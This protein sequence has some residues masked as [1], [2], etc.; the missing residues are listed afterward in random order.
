MF[1]EVTVGGNSLMVEN[2]GNG[3]AKEI[4]INLRAVPSDEGGSR[5]QETVDITLPTIAPGESVAVSRGLEELTNPRERQEMSEEELEERGFG[6]LGFTD[7]ITE[8]DLE[9]MGK[10]VMQGSCRD[11]LDNE[12]SVHSEYYVKYLEEGYAQYGSFDTNEQL[13]EIAQYM[14][15]VQSQLRDISR[16]LG[17]Y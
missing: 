11:I 3:P 7:N 2:V 14:R 5:S 8:A 4:D 6:V 9:D 17:R 13:N 16:S 10:V 15:D 1:L 12:H